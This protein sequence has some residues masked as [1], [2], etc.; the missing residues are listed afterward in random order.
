M[1]A[2]YFV[3][4]NLEVI[5]FLGRCNGE[6]DC[7]DGSDENNCTNTTGI[8]DGVI[9]DKTKKKNKKTN[10]NNKNNNKK[11]NKKKKKRQKK[12]PTKQ[13]QQNQ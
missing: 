6:F 11:K 4:R 9:L 5:S 1:P 13:Q 8:I 7:L 12:P 3:C 10:N 2:S